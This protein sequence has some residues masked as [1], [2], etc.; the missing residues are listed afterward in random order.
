[1]FDIFQVFH[2]QKNVNKSKNV[3]FFSSITRV[4]FASSI[5]FYDNT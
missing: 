4:L 2:V 5:Q 1:M 3:Q